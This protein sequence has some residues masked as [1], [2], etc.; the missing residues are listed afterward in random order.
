M[1]RSMLFRQPANRILARE[2][3]SSGF[4]YGKNP[5]IPNFSFKTGRNENFDHSLKR[6]RPT[7]PLPTLKQDL[8]YLQQ[9]DPKRR[10]QQFC[11]S[12]VLGFVRSTNEVADEKN[13][14]LIRKFLEFCKNTLVDLRR[15]QIIP[16]RIFY[17]RRTLRG[18]MNFSAQAI[19]LQHLEPSESSRKLI[20]EAYERFGRSRKLWKAL[21]D[22][23][24]QTLKL[25]INK[26]KHAFINLLNRRQANTNIESQQQL[27]VVLDPIP[28]VIP[29]SVNPPQEET[30]STMEVPVTKSPPY[31]GSRHDVNLPQEETT[32]TMEVPVTES[33]PYPD[34][35]HD[36][37]TTNVIADAW[38]RPSLTDEQIDDAF[39][40]LI[41]PD[42]SQPAV[43]DSPPGW[44]SDSD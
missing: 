29:V 12:Y 36:E 14:L 42:N 41:W 39:A 21:S 17:A 23:D 27:D 4:T 20:L 34:T 40:K 28:V 22:I 11:L 8:F 37:P 32:S 38:N 26:A 43:T 3:N 13:I 33:P 6:R 31:Q 16:A 10:F 44:N 7:M 1:C 35:R 25:K 9:P 24:E 5:Q 2:R 30:T 19:L 15:I 18:L